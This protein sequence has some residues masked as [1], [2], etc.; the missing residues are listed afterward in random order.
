MPNSLGITKERIGQI[1]DIATS[2]VQKDKSL[3]DHFIHSY[4]QPLHHETAETIS[5]ADLAGM[6]LH[7]FTLLKA[8]D[9]KKPQLAILNPI[10]EEQHFHSS[11]TVI[12]IVAYDRPFL[13]D[14]ILMSLE[15]LGIDV[16]RTYNIILNVERD[17]N[18]NIS[19]VESVHESN[20]SH[21]SLIHCEISYQD[22][23]ELNA[24]KKMLL[25]KIDTLDI[26]V[27]DWQ[28]I[29]ARLT[30]IKTDL[31][32]KPLPEVFYSKE[33]IQAFLDWV[34]DEHFIFLGYREYRLE[35]GDN[36]DL[37]AIGNSGL[38]LLRGGS[39]DTLSKSFDELPSNL[40][41]LL[42]EPRVLMLSKS[43]R[44]SPVHRPVYMD[45]LGIHKF[46][47]NGKLI[48]EYRFI[49]LFTPQ[50]YQLSVQQIPLLREKANK[51]MEM[52]DLPRDGHAYHKMIHVIN[53]LPRDDLFQASVEELYPTVLGIS[54]LQD[55]KSLRLFTRI[56]HYQRFVS[57]LVYIPRD[58]F[59]T[60]L[61]IKVQ[62]V[63][64]EAYGGTSSGFTTEFNESEHA[65]VH[66]HVRTVPGQVND[67]DT[68]ALEAKLSALMQSWSDNYQKM[69]LDNVGEQQANALMRRFLRYIPAAYQERFD[70]RTAVED[71]KRLAGL[72]DEQPIIWHLYQSTGDAGN[73]LHL[74]LY[75]RQQPVILSKVLPILEN[76]G[77]SVISA[78]T[79]EFD[80]PEQP[81]WMQEYEL[82]LE[83]VDT[84]NMQVVRAQFEDSLKQIW[85]GRIESDSFN[86][87]VLTT[88]LD[89][90]DVVVLR[91]LSRYMLQA[92][93]PFSSAYIQQTVVKNS[94]I[95]VALSDL[96]NARMNPKYSEEER[97]S[98]TSQIQEQITTA[99][100]D[101]SSLDEDRILRWYL[102]LINAMVRTNFYQ[103]EADGQRKDRLSFK[104]LAAD[105]PNLPKPKPMFEIFVHS[106]RVE[107]VHLR[108]GKVARG[109]LRWSDRMEDFRTEV[110]GLVKAQMVKN[111]VIVPVGSKGG[112]IVKTKTMADGRE[113][114]QAEGIAC[115]QAFLRGM[116][117]ITDNIVDGKIVPPADTVRHDE[118]DPYLVVAADKGTA[119]FSDI[120]NALSSEYNF[121]LDD[122]FASGGSVGYDHKAM[123]ITARGGWESVKRHFRMRGMDIQN[124]DDF[125][126]VGIGDMSGDVFGN[127]MLRSIHTKL[128]AA[129]N[130]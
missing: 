97:A 84:I 94:D 38:G 86:E 87:L 119:T 113:A 5:D 77:V 85:A 130:H 103:R 129:F 127:G 21:M 53:S 52:A 128:V 20:T 9:D 59:N 36:L 56:D 48:G 17:E 78:Q 62:N 96:F 99:L 71:T 112:F 118:D 37:F 100:A 55:K 28:Q 93:A 73:Q 40:K 14:T 68:A 89:T 26:V 115:Y 12:Q 126:V 60:E 2:Y 8:Y 54:Q 90:Y 61:R 64:K 125:T 27:D 34:L 10:A 76:F 95:S 91:A 67:V 66:V 47:D 79:Y 124:R 32:S 42:T 13:V 101:V 72:S 88:K 109:G 121:W 19:H 46:D 82:I 80:L 35:D 65:R 33:E 51:I 31:G 45:F 74:K 75:G 15:E 58:K 63:L 4:Y 116:L 30:D 6:A 105:I 29:R 120:A 107:A 81:I 41:K 16:H 50:A 39:E 106:P 111:A 11:H 122:A 110:L 23:N 57:C 117:D 1:S 18:N 44:V 102:D 25:A 108:G 83:H 114:F 92:K 7:H 22:N 43:S 24:L 123:G 3:F 69:L 49:G 98:K 70:A 104:F